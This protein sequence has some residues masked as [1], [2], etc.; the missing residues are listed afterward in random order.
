MKL[1]GCKI[2]IMIEFRSLY[3]LNLV[4]DYVTN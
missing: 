4:N 1:R 2:A 3:P